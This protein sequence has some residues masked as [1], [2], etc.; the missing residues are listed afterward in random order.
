[1]NNRLT[2]Q[3]IAGL[4][5]EKTGKSKADAERFLRTFISVVGEGL[6]MD[7]LVKI[8]GLGTFKLVLVEQRESVD[9]NTGERFVLPA[10]YKCSFLP[11][12]EMKEL[13][14]EPFSF[15]ET[16]ELAE[17][18]DVADLAVPEEEGE[19]EEEAEAAQEEV[20][21]VV[22]A[23]EA[24]PVEESKP[25]PQ[26]EK[27]VQPKMIPVIKEPI[28]VS[29]PR[30]RQ[31]KGVLGA[32]GVVLVIVCVVLLYLYM[33]SGYVVND[34]AAPTVVIT[35]DPALLL[36]KET[37][38]MIPEFLPADS[39]AIKEE[40]SVPFKEVRIIKV[41]E[42]DRLTYL[43]EKY[44]GS[45]AFWVYIYQFNKT[46]IRNPDVITVGMELILPDPALYEIDANDP[47]SIQRAHELEKQIKGI[48]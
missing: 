3:D 48:K 27:P 40:T 17:G 39:L 12:A 24:L 31:R 44:Y 16:T 32:V 26:P 9:V 34:T 23:P 37:E 43:A 14:N 46:V 20:K 33:G 5:A 15:F 28:A 41:G 18:V 25:I 8:K 21:A 47:A 4:V 42:D 35:E 19:Q 13:V 11:D 6:M 22:A 38:E 7:K 2:V 29:K 30:A 45:R 1:M 36:Q 10:H